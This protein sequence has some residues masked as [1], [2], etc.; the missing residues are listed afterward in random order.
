MNHN[1]ILLVHGYSDQAP[2]FLKWKEALVGKG[3]APEKIH[4]ICYKSLTNEVTIKDIAE[5][6]ERALRLKS[7]LGET[8]QFDAIVH[9]TGML[10][11]RAW[12]TKYPQ[13]KDRLK[14][15]VAL[16]PATFGSPLAHRGRSWIGSIFK[17][18]KE[19]GP[20]FGE[21]G[22]LILDALELGSKFTWDLAMEDLVGTKTYYGPDNSTP[23]VFVLCGNKG[24][25]GLGRL[26]SERGSD[27]TVRWAGCALNSRKI[28][29][30]LTKPAE[31][32]A[33]RYRISKFSNENIPLVLLPNL[34]HGTI[35][36]E[37]SKLAVDL[38]DRALRVDT[39]EASD[40]WLAFAR[41]KTAGAFKPSDEFQQFVVHAHDERGDPIPDFNILLHTKNANG[42]WQPL[43]DFDL[44]PHS[45]SSDKSFKSFHVNLGKLKPAN[46]DSLAVEIIAS[47]GTEDVGYLG[48]PSDGIKQLQ[49]V[50]IDITAMLT[51]DFKFFYPFTTTLIELRLNREPLP[52]ELPSQVCLFWEANR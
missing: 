10:V 9:S 18:S 36:S 7:G 23:Y 4:L 11:L 38:V 21:A 35:L 25:G 52:D 20:D 24:Y 49:R 2:S 45:Y 12:L 50:M 30:D 43:K 5:A 40:A 41:A 17:A 13:R 22:D 44:E 51:Q 33:E 6:F 37:P 14:R 8:A 15:L 28:E 29:M 19:V 34:N 47:S 3:F 32:N 26:I 42:V 1:P 48:Y 31:P 39:K 46:L 16:A 27:G